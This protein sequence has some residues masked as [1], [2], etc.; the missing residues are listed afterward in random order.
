MLIITKITYFP[1][2]EDILIDFDMGD[3]YLFDKYVSSDTLQAMK[4]QFRLTNTN[5]LVGF[6]VDGVNEIS[7][8][9]GNYN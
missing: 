5:D 2:T 7:F 6:E 1:D 4:K 8:L 9:L 3:G